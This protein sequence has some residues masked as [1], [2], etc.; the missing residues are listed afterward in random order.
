LK[1]TCKSNLEIVDM[2]RKIQILKLLIRFQQ[3]HG[4]RQK[5]N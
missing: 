2:E 3:G 1:A 4:N 5:D